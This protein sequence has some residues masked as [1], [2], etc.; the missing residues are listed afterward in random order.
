MG[1]IGFIT[2]QS[3][4][5]ILGG[6]ISELVAPWGALWHRVQKGIYSLLCD[7]I[8]RRL[9]VPQG[10]LDALKLALFMNCGVSSA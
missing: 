7:P 2:E 5:V 1:Q 8:S 10:T 9:E 3:M 4:H 6:A